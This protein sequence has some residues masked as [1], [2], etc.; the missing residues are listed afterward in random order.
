MSQSEFAAL[1]TRTRFKKLDCTCTTEVLT[2]HPNWDWRRLHDADLCDTGLWIENQYLQSFRLSLLFISRNHYLPELPDPLNRISIASTISHF[3]GKAENCP[4]SFCRVVTNWTVCDLSPVSNRVP[5][6]VVWRF[7]YQP[8]TAHALDVSQS[9]SRDGC[10]FM[11]IFAPITSHDEMNA[12]LCIHIH[13]HQSG[14]SLIHTQKP[15]TYA[16]SLV[17]H[18]GCGRFAA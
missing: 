1:A 9:I 4:K 5:L 18:D 12:C 16:H 14:W 7:K 2:T 13:I 10:L 17:N 15:E 3:G 6:D 8:W 11:Q